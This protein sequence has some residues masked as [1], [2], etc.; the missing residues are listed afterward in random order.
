[1]EGVQ[2]GVSLRVDL[3]AAVGAEGGA[4]K[5]AMLRQ[6]L[7]VVGL[8]ELLYQSR[9]AVDVCQQ[10]GD[11]SRRQLTIGHSNN[12]RGSE[13]QMSSS[14][15]P[16]FLGSMR[17]RGSC[18]ALPRAAQG[19]PEEPGTCPQDLSPNRSPA[20]AERVV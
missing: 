6:C 8:A 17:L 13:G 19:G 10:H 9:R 16:W 12:A 11:I 3:D 5:T 7:D 18:E 1:G 15:R 4:Q 2:K 20:V 14:R